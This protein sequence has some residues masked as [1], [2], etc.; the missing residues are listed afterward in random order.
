MRKRW[1]LVGMIFLLVPWLLVSCGVAQEEYDAAVSEL[2]KVQ[3]ELQSVKAELEATQTDLAASETTVSSLEAAL[4]NANSA[5]QAQQNI[6]L[7]LSEEQKTVKSPRHFQSIQELT[8]WLYEDD[9]DTE[10]ADETPS[11]MAY[12]L[13]V[14]A[15]RDGYLLPVDIDVEGDTYYVSNATIIG[16]SL[17]WVYPWDDDTE[18]ASYVDPIPSYPLPLD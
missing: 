11:I 2:G 8:N 14:R 6:N 9:T 10:Y 17:Y 4:E 16:D 18:W 12:I 7:A 3:E 1:F 13:Q 5:L 15:L